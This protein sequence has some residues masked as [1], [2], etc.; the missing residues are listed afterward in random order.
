MAAL[1]AA[2]AWVTPADA[3]K[4]ACVGDSITYGYG[5][6]NPA[7]EAYPAVLQTLL[8]GE[9][10]V[11]N[12]GVSGATLLKKGDKPYWNEGAFTS[13]GS[14][15][16]DVVVI[17][18]GTNDAKPT[19]W[20]HKAEFSGDYADLIDQ[21]RTLGALVY[22]AAPPPVYDPGAFDIPPDVVAHEVVPLVEQVAT[23]AN[24]PLI[25]VFQA[26]SGKAPNFPDTVHPDAAGA[27]LIAE[28]VQ[29]AL[30]EHG[31]GGAT[32]TG[33]AGG[34]GAGPSGGADT[35]SGGAATGGAG[36]ATSGGSAGS[37]GASSGGAIITAGTHP[38]GGATPTGGVDAG[39]GTIGTG[40]VAPTGGVHAGGSTIGTGGAAPTGG[41]PA[42][43][44]SRGTAATGGAN[45]SG[46]AIP[47]GGTAGA[48]GTASAAQTGGS[49]SG[50]VSTRGGAS[51]AATGGSRAAS[52]SPSATSA[53]TEEGG[54]GCHMGARGSLPWGAHVVGTIVGLVVGRRRRRATLSRQSSIG[55]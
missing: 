18:L 45:A 55:A 36:G 42:V 4:I 1:L 32:A 21:Y 51:G 46:G 24:A 10:T 29:A 9:H 25:D 28:T 23:D 44:G 6:G 20:S 7:T 47:L 40:G 52:G 34:T 54:C 15:D 8:G 49:A 27:R 14:F 53:A 2:L 12:F 39:G 41:A 11:Q 43:G 19:N 22:V 26:L 48:G 13:S 16:P 38:D 3:A 37:G 50:G 17:M 31:F 5:L 35:D 30:E 33:G